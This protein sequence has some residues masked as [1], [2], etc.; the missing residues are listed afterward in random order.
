MSIVFSK[1]IADCVKLHGCFFEEMRSCARVLGH[2]I[3][4]KVTATLRMV[5]EF[6]QILLVTI[7]QW[8]RASASIKCIKRFL[9]A[10][11]A[12]LGLST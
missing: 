9:V 1:H 10:M 4:Q 7:C 8:V 12:F 6:M 2:S 11:V 5:A 3:Y